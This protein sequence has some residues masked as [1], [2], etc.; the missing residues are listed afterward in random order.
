MTENMSTG[1]NLK[2]YPGLFANKEPIAA[3]SAFSY[4]PTVRNDPKE[5]NVFNSDGKGKPVCTYDRLFNWKEGYDNKL[6]RCDREHAKLKGLST[7]DEEKEKVIPT[8]NSTE[9]GHRLD[10]FKDNPD[11]LHVRV[12]HVNSEFFR[13]TGINISADTH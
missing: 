12:G 5:Q 4:I 6:H 8:L 7:N 3:K 10:E 1:K 13:R 11:R 2:D 9:Y